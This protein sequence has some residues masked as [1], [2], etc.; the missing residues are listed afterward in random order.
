M[1]ALMQSLL[2]TAPWNKRDNPATMTQGHKLVQWASLKL[3][4]RWGSM[5][6][7]E[8]LKGMRI[9]DEPAVFNHIIDSTT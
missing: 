1:T 7:L 2:Q 4:K 9:N 8:A 5:P 6:E 3:Y